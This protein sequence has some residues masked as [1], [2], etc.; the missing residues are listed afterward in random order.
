MTIE[1]VGVKGHSTHTQMLYTH[2]LT[3]RTTLITQ[4]NGHERDFL[5]NDR[6]FIMDMYNK[7]I[8]PN[9]REAKGEGRW[10]EVHVIGRWRGKC[11]GSVESEGGGGWVKGE[12]GE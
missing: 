7:W 1:S 9:D 3:T 4:G 11:L 8:Y 2:T 5:D 12:C 6:V 10:E